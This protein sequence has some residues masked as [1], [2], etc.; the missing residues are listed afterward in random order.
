MQYVIGSFNIANM[1]LTKDF[2]EIAR[3]IRKNKFDV[4]AIQEV[5]TDNAIKNLVNTLNRMDYQTWEGVCESSDSYYQHSN[6][7]YG[8]V[9]NKKRLRLA[10]EPW[11]VKRYKAKGICEGGIVRPPYVARFTPSGL[12]G[13]TFFEI[14]L[15][16]THIL[17]GKPKA[18]LDELRDEELR[19]QELTLIAKRI[20]SSVADK[21][22]GDNMPSYTFLLGD[23]NLC[24]V[25]KGPKI[26]ATIN[27]G[28]NRVLVNDQLLP[29]S[30]KD[31]MNDSQGESSQDGKDFSINNTADYYASNFD[32]FSYESNMK[33][34]LSL[35]V[36]RVNALE[37][38]MRRNK[39]DID[40]F[41]QFRNKISDHVPIKLVL[42]LSPSA[43]IK[44]MADM[45]IQEVSSKWNTIKNN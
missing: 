10:N 43:V 32:H 4:I 31:H 9:W 14:R 44:E 30:L 12:L 39:N 5:T 20:Y 42:D 22:Y 40:G 27:I 3:I 36:H 35:T 34:R 38:Y 8:F 41:E 23:Y 29:T 1:N 26:A 24:L 28:N 17:F 11:I 7:W 25:G 6:E 21:R 15:I 37:D 33:E 18:A 19:R 13:G 2:S 16:N 45:C